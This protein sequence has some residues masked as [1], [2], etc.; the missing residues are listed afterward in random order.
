MVFL[1]TTDETERSRMQAIGRAA[2]ELRRQEY[3]QLAVQLTNNF[4][5]MLGG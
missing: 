2:S 3:E 4:Q 1:E 5:K